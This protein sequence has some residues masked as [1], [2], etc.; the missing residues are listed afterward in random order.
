MVSAKRREMGFPLRWYSIPNVF[1]YERPQ[2]GRLR[3]H[4]Q[5]NV[6]LF[7]ASGAYAD[8]EIIAVAHALVIAFGGTE[9]DFV[10]KLGSRNFLDGIVKELGLSGENAK[11]LRSVLDRKNKMPSEEFAR[12]MTDLGVASELLGDAPPQ[13]VAEVIAIL[14]EMGITNAVFDPA[15]VRG[16]DYYT[17]IVFE[18]FDTHPENNRAMFG[19]GRY[20]GLT[21][22]F[23]GE[24]LP[25]VGMAA[26]D[27]TFSDFLRVRGLL[28]E[29]APHAKVY[30]AIAKKELAQEAFAL[31]SVLR[32]ENVAAAIDFGEK[33]LGEQIKTAVKHKIPYVIVVG[34]DEVASGTFKV[35]DLATGQETPL[36]KA[37]LSNFFLTL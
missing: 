7:G 36:K 22:L 8:A 26:G 32:K 25:A 21:S 16:F 18:L 15:I 3:E 6:D 27:V 14:Q 17:G 1:R 37:E 31:A 4:W 13:D 11:K 33:K 10:I 35:K 2:H 20:D 19:G 24:N 9:K 30:I 5:L 12:E 28:P 23:D 29:Y 34:E